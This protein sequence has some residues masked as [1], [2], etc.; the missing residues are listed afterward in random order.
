MCRLYEEHGIDLGD[1]Q[2]VAGMPKAALAGQI[3]MAPPG[4]L[5]DR[6]SRRL[7]DP[8]TAMASGWMRIRQRARQRNVELPLII[9]DHA[10]WD[11]LTH[12]IQEVN[13]QETWITH[14][15]EEAL[16]RWCEL[17]QRKARALALVGY[18]DE[19]D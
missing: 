10:D 14:G 6:W 16:L 3:V 11:E 18:E 4:A 9:S 5:N 7:P 8:I 13:P 17:N 1:L 19:D 12:T 2:L 15:R